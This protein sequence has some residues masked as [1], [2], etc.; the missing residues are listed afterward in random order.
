MCVNDNNNKR[1]DGKIDP[2]DGA[3]EFPAVQTPTLAC[4]GGNGTLH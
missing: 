3:F 1:L 2:G 4:I